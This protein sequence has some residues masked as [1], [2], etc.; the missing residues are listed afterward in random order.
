MITISDG[1]LNIPECERFVGFTGDNNHTQ[2]KFFI[3]NN[4]ESGWIYRLYLTFDDGRQ[5]FFTL[6]ATTVEGGTILEW[7]IQE[8]HLFKSGLVRAQIKAFSEDNEVYHTTSDVFVAGKTAEEDEYF[9]NSNSEFLAY[10]K[11]LNDLY[12]KMKNASAKMPYVGENGNWFFYDVNS[13]SYKDS[14]VSSSAGVADNTVTPE[15]LDRKYYERC[16]TE[17]GETVNSFAQL[18]EKVGR[19]NRGGKLGFIKLDVSDNDNDSVL[20]YGYISGDF[21]AVGTPTN[22]DICLINLRSGENWTVTKNDE[23]KYSAYKV[24]ALTPRVVQLEENARITVLGEINSLSELT[25]RYFSKDILYH[26]CATGSLGEHIGEGFCFGRY[27]EEVNAETGAIINKFL[28]VFNS[29]TLKTWKIDFKN[30]TAELIAYGNEDVSEALSKKVDFVTLNLPSGSNGDEEL[31]EYLALF[32]TGCIGTAGGGKGYP[33]IFES[34]TA[35]SGVEITE[36]L[37]AHVIQYKTY[38]KGTDVNKKFKRMYAHDGNEP[39]WTDWE[40]AEPQYAGAQVISLGTLETSDIQNYAFEE[41]ILY[42]FDYRDYDCLAVFFNYKHALKFICFNSGITGDID[43]VTG[44]ITERGGGKGEDGVS[45]TV[46]VTDIDGGKMVSITDVNGHK[47]F[48]ILNGADGED[49]VGV[50]SAEI[51]A[52][53]E[54]VLTYTNGSISMVG[55]VKG[56]DGSAVDLEKNSEVWTFTLSDGSTV[57]KKVVLA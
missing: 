16:V 48:E 5:N 22:S 31:K 50:K 29:T 23:E 15:K 38:L 39:V 28:E 6:P 21:M 1:I 46:S 9:K 2:K 13:D 49:G 34:Y 53:G 20:N 26:F 45:P 54:L 4:P 12:R 27:S 14:G 11:I 24:D 43:T 17:Y 7:N 3:R 51:N 55:K 30:S 32:G 42:R 35:P 56:E 47:S 36:G 57:T 41:D 25:A 10:E 44:E 8:D 52:N 18:F 37:Y 19:I 40:L 33:F